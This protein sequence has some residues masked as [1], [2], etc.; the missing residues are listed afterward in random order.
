MKNNECIETL[1]S[2]QFITTIEIITTYS[3]IPNHMLTQYGIF[4][5]CAW[6]CAHNDFL[7]T[8][9]CTKG[10]ALCSKARP[11]LIGGSELIHIDYTIH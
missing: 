8:K 3:A 4:V 1:F 10:V 7:C 2:F 11:V 6:N 5:F 9:L